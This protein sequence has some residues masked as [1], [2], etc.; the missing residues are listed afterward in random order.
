[1]ENYRPQ[2][3]DIVWLNFSPSQVKEIKVK[4]PALVVS[5]NEYNRSTSYVIVCPV[6]TSGNH[7]PSY[8]E[9]NHYPHVK[10]RVNTSQIHSFDLTRIDRDHGPLDQT[11]LEDMVKVQSVLKFALNI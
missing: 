2:F 7:H 8:I 9:L 1:M 10:G 5:S 3:G 6:T 4:R 11:R